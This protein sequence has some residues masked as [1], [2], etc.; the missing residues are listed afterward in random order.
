MLNLIWSLWGHF[1]S[2]R[3]R[4]RRNR[5]TRRRAPPAVRRCRRRRRVARR[6]ARRATGRLPAVPRAWSV[7]RPLR[8]PNRWRFRRPSLRLRAAP[9]AVRRPFA[10]GWGRRRNPSGGSRRAA[11]R[12]FAF[13]AA[14]KDFHLQ[15]ALQLLI[16]LHSLIRSVSLEAL[17]SVLLC[18]HRFNVALNNAIESIRRMHWIRLISIG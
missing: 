2:R 17:E 7:A 18:F 3:R 9:R 14:A 6:F 1:S 13:R 12:G 10:G 8:A 5:P 11:R 16:Q 4:E 15:F